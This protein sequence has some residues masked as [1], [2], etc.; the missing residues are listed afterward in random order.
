MISQEQ[1]LDYCAYKGSKTYRFIFIDGTILEST[2][3]TLNEA[4]IDLNYQLSEVDY[5]EEI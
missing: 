5:W 3:Y 1:F 2:G 4:Y